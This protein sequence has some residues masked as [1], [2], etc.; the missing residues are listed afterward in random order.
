[1]GLTQSQQDA[2]WRHFQN[3]STESFDAS[4]SRLRFLAERC[5]PGSRVL[6]IGVGSGCLEGLLVKRG[7]VAYALDPSEETIARI[8]SQ[9]GMGDRAQCGYSDAI[10]FPS[11]TFDKVIMTE[12]LEH[13]PEAALHATLSEVSRVL[14]PGGVFTGTVPFSE[15]LR[16][17]EVL[18][19]NCGAIFHRWGHVTSFGRDDLRGLLTQH[20]FVVARLYPRCFPDFRRPGLKAFMRAL[21]RQVLGRMGEPI[22][23]PNLYFVAR[24]GR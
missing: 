5:V 9:L 17:N 20:G 11:G 19:P 7:V 4:Y 12:V 1:M 16:D 15:R 14:V 21:F 6:N 18:C 10:P 24:A 23:G 13:L 2:L 3:H 22:V 8:G